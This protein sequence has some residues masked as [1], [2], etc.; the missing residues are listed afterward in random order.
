MGSTAVAKILAA[1]AGVDGLVPGDFVRAA[2][3]MVLVNELSANR[4][5]DLFDELGAGAVFDPSRV[6]VVPDHFTPAKDLQAA[7]LCA[8]VRDFARRSGVRY[9]EVGRGG[10]EHCLLPEEGL[11]APGDVVVG[12][13]SHTCTYGALGAFA[14]GVGATDVAVAWAL[15]DVWLRVPE[16]RVVE[17]RGRLADPCCGKDVVLALLGRIGVDGARYETLEY[18]GEGVASL[19]MPYR[20]TIANMAIEGGAKNALFPVDEVTLAYLASRGVPSGAGRSFAS[21]ADASLVGR[22]ELDLAALEPS[23][24]APDLPSNV[25]PARS[26][27]DVTVDQVVIGC[28]TNGWLEDL[29]EAAAVLRGRRVHERVR[30]I[31]VPGTQDILRRA[32][33]DGTVAVFLAAGAVVAPPGCGPCLGGHMGV[34]AAGETAVSTTNR[35]FTG[36]MGHRDAGIWLAGPRVAAASAVTGRITDPREVT[37]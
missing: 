28:C 31:V 3:S 19:S 4:A 17:L 8:K 33:D 18:R 26:C 2:C 10:V 30:C 9:Y 24:A 25:R 16:T 15:G 23:V 6:V 21:D 7:A 36:R 27:G 32:V 37:A 22:E 29:H 1:A 20:F 5:I 34:L 12:G 13:D 14:A 35:N 11:V